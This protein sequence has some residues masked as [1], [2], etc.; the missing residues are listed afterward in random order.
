MSGFGIRC[1]VRDLIDR[2]I[3]FM[4]EKEFVL[5]PPSDYENVA[6]KQILV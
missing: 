2:N 4:L 6:F 3:S 1:E 5:G